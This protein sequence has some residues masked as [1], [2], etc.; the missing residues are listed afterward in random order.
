MSGSY[1]TREYFYTKRGTSRHFSS[2]TAAAMSAASEYV[3]LA[4]GHMEP[5]CCPS[6]P[7]LISSYELTYLYGCTSL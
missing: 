2:L 7:V 4:W 5:F 1:Q 3:Y 6:I